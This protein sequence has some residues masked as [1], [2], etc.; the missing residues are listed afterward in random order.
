[1]NASKNC[2]CGHHHDHGD[3]CETARRPRVCDLKTEYLVNPMGMDE[4]APRFSYQL[5][6]VQVQ[7]ARQIQVKDEFGALAW[8]S[9]WVS[10]GRSQQIAYEG[11]A[12]RPFTRYTL[13]VRVKDEAGKA[14]SWSEEDAWFETGFLDA[15]WKHSKWITYW[16]GPRYDLAPQLFNHTI[17]LPAKKIAKA[18][19][20]GT[21]LGVYE[22]LING[23]NVTDWVFT[24]GWTNY[25][26]RV[27]YQCFDVTALL[28]KGDNDLR[29]TL[30]G[31]WFH[32]RIA[33]H[34]NNGEVPYGK[35]EMLRCEIHVTFADGS[36]QVIGSSQDFRTN[37]QGGPLR[38]SDIYDGEIYEAWRTP[39]WLEKTGPWFPAIETDT[40]TQVVW[41]SGAPVRRL[42]VREPE[43]I[44]R[45]GGSTWVVDFGQNLTGR[46]RLILHNT[47]KGQALV[48]KHGEMLDADGSV[49]VANLRS[50]KALTVYTADTAKVATYE[51]TFTFFGFRYLEIS[52]WNGRLTKKDVQ[53][54]VIS[55]DLPRTGLFA[56]SDDMLNRL[57][58]NVGW[59]LRSNFLDVPT[60]CPQRDERFG[61][62][63]DTQVFCNAATYNVWAPAFYA[64]WVTDL[65]LGQRTDGAYEFTAPGTTLSPGR[66]ATGWGDAALIVPWRLYVKYG[67]TR[68]L[69]KY[70]DNMDRYLKLE[71]ANSKG[72]CVV[73]NLHFGD[74]LH[75]DAPT[76]K[77]LIGTAYFAGSSRLL[78]RIA[79]ILGKAGAA[80]R[81]QAQY[82]KA[83]KAFQENFLNKN[84][85]KEKTQTACLLALHFDLLPEELVL[86]TVK[87]L[88][89]DITVNRKLHLS[90]G[91]LGTPLLLPVLTRFGQLD[92]AYDLLMQTTY[93]GWLYPVTQGATTMW[94]R[95]NSY[96]RETG[97]GNVDMNSFNH[98]AYGAVA[99]W[100]Y[101]TIAGIQPIEDEPA[102]L[103]FK[104]FRL[105]P[106]PGKRL[107][108]ASAVFFS[109]YG[110]I[111]SSWLRN[112]KKHTITWSFTVPD[113]TTAEITL[114]ASEVLDFSGTC[115]LQHDTAGNLLALPGEYEVTF[116]LNH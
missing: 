39:E 76:S 53:A 41:N 56:C 93:P 44:T 112:R 15:P 103:A 69:E 8:D 96:T 24:P 36:T 6:G 5:A 33:H 11:K 57:Y 50:A 58:E 17:T 46:E 66:P 95:W 14:T 55:S 1:M 85:L 67:E 16:Q 34:W 114:P 2:S 77:A 71:L 7:G 13:R 49:Y 108:S 87:L 19:Y 73:D 84:G 47:V 100:F 12:L 51:P 42:Q 23:Q 116:Q 81:L 27:Q 91:F 102:A 28:K 88:V 74:W 54:V 18:R 109:P 80:R 29:I 89:K 111:S 110:M 90:T 25:F 43:K 21:A 38:M 20:Y 63:G 52:G 26:H 62:T 94:E 99:E 115:E 22:A 35:N 105:A 113:N 98:Y 106:Q 78:A 104:R 48:V 86:P 107:D 60:D 31:G 64:K 72:T 40:K 101:E 59:G 3:H 68:L 83:R 9:G 10:D 30:G 97:F 70:F 45:R 61:W 4:P 79:K 37:N 32:G 65:N 75:I 92:L 82:R